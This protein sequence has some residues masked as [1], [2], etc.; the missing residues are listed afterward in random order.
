MFRTV[1][2][3][4][5]SFDVEWVPDPLSAARLFDLSVETP[6]ERA[7]A[8]ERLWKHGGATEE[9]PRPYLKTI[10]CRVVTLAGVLREAPARDG[11]PPN[12]RLISLPTRPDLDWREQEIH[13][14]KGF[15]EAM[16]RRRPQLVGYNSS[17]ADVPI[18]VQRAVVHGL[19]SH[20]F[21]ERPEKPWLGV[22]YF[23]TASES[24]V[25]LG[26][27][28]GRYGQMPTLHEAAV[29]SGI[30]GKID[31]SGANVVALWLQDRL[32]EIRAYN[33][34][35]A[36]S[37][38]LLWARVAHFIGVLS[39]AAYAAEQAAVRALAEAGAG[40][41]GGAHFR[42]FLAVWDH[43]QREL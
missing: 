40:R 37:T 11:D 13:I 42:R 34:C 1:Q 15:L 19:E 3:L 6:G 32:G 16:G 33:E 2:P 9:T 4:V 27:L 22:D 31:Q 20:G 24:S 17:R 18:L 8:I 29:C 10:L 36:L 23:S 25:D 7:T 39:P 30:P 12:L 35:D 21:A 38:H 5:F 28:L 41:E 26:P 43:L 14:L